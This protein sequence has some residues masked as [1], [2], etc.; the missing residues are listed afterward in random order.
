MVRRD[1]GSKARAGCNATWLVT[2]GI[3]RWIQACG[4]KMA[5]RVKPTGDQN[6]PGLAK[7]RPKQEGR[8]PPLRVRSESDRGVRDSVEPNVPA[9]TTKVAVDLKGGFGLIG[10]DMVFACPAPNLRLKP[11]VG[12]QDVVDEYALEATRGRF[13]DR[14]LLGKG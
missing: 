5:C 13:L 6:G 1:K 3:I 7:G 10:I 12:A 9:G 2:R 4:R 14:S 11:L 8:R